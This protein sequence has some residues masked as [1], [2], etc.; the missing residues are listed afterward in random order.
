MDMFTEGDVVSFDTMSWAWGHKMPIPKKGL[1]FKA[2][3]GETWRYHFCIILGS[4]LLGFGWHIVKMGEL[5]QELQNC[6]FIFVPKSSRNLGYDDCTPCSKGHSGRWPNS[7]SSWKISPQTIP[8]LDDQ[9]EVWT[10]FSTSI[11]IFFIWF[12]Q[13]Y[14]MCQAIIGW[15]S[16][17]CSVS[18]INIYVFFSWIFR[19]G[20]A[21][22]RGR[23][24]PS[25]V[26]AAPVPGAWGAGGQGRSGRG[27]LQS[28]LLVRRRRYSVS[29]T[30][31]LCPISIHRLI[32]QGHL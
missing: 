25:L 1:T 19:R 4:T 11:P 8:I 14:A 28:P 5:W 18:L 16:C 6:L 12:S 27:L 3:E 10:E 15:N 13:K 32:L 29:Y 21:V 26:L 9:F 20:D 31:L 7:V 22:G 23:R 24:P 17:Q 30:F 2:K